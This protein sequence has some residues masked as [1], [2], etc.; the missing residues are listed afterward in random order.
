MNVYEIVTQKII[1]KLDHGVI[2]WRRPWNAP[3][4]RNWQSGK[5][6]SGINRLLLGCGEYVT[7]KQCA[8][9]GGKIKKGE[10]SHIAVFFK[11]YEK[12]DDQT[13][14]AEKWPVLRYYNVFEISQCEGLETKSPDFKPLDF[15]PI[16]AAEDILAAYKD[17]PQIRHE[18]PRA[19]YV[20]A[21]DYVNMPRKERFKSVEEYYST[22]FHELTHSTGHAKRLN[23]KGGSRFGSAAYSRE[24]LVAEIGAAMLCGVAHIDNATLDNSAA[25]ID[26]WRRALKADCHLIVTAAQQAQKAA[27]YIRGIQ[28]D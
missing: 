18:E 1:E 6:Y 26:S 17:K 24:E 10:K 11:W 12:E 22:L 8:E 21:L 5:E 7:F 28:E 14:E 19:Y 9:A 25:Y 23:R 20:P 27:N 13:G 4:A 15:D 2:P 16:E 3:T